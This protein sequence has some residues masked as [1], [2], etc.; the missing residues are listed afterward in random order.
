MVLTLSALSTA[1]ATDGLEA[2]ISGA[3]FSGD[4]RR[5]LK[6]HGF[7]VITPS[8]YERGKQQSYSDKRRVALTN[9]PYESIYNH[10]A[11][12]EFLL[13]MKGYARDILVQA[14]RQRVSGSV[15]EKLPYIYLNALKNLPERATLF[16]YD[17]TGWKKGGIKWMRAKAKEHDGLYVMKFDEFKKWLKAL[18]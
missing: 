7:L 18:R 17:G 2:N 15:D 11:R 6:L 8:E 13:I 4:V 5:E 9:T 3:R 12:M 14:K 16:V 1:Q 10:D